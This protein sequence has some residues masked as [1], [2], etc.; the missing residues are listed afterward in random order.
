[1][2][3]LICLTCTRRA[4]FKSFWRESSPMFWYWWMNLGFAHAGWTQFMKN[5][6]NCAQLSTALLMETRP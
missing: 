6:H 1:M 5:I 2:A 3:I 4:L